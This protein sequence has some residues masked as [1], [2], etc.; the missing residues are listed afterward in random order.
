[1]H[2]IEAEGIIK[3]YEIS[4]MNLDDF[5]NNLKIKIISK[6]ENC[7]EFDIL[8]CHPSIANT[9]RRTMISLVPTMAVHNVSIYENN[10]VFPDEYLA[11][12]LGLIPL[13][14]NP[15]YFN[16]FNDEETFDNVLTFKI[17]KTATEEN[18]NL[19]SNDI[20]FVP[21]EGQD[22]FNFSFVPNV[23]ICQMVPGNQINMTFKAIKGRGKDHTKW[24]PVSLCSYR[25]MPRIVLE[26]DFFGEEAIELQ[27]CFS[28]GVIDII[29]NKAVV[30]NPRLES[31]SREVFRHDKFKDSVKILRENGWF[32]FTVETI[33]HD[34][35][36]I[37]KMGFE[38]LIRKCK[39]LKQEVEQ[40]VKL[41]N[42]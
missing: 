34:P 12:R 33:V 17:N 14:V 3:D 2:K 1:M 42:D 19:L 9:L 7:I 13:D 25:L 41:I 8:N 28:P 23:L 5:I 11:H 24:S 10:T 30:V 29:N 32:C 20:E 22:Q 39:E 31:M 26:K 35:I 38:E 15:E 40:S 37:L 18:T 16:F 21:I 6:S 4:N 36:K 27:K